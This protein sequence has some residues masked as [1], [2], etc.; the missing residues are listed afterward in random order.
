MRGAFRTPLYVLKAQKAYRERNAEK[1]AEKAREKYARNRE[2]I[3]EKAKQSRAE[4]KTD[5]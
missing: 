4:K 2:T 3:L 1:L 5:S